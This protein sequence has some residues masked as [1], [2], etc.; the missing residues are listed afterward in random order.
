MQSRVALQLDWFNS[1]PSGAGTINVL[2]WD[3]VAQIGLTENL[4]LDADLPWSY[5][6]IDGVALSPSLFNVSKAVF[7]VPFVGA[8]LAARVSPTSGFFFGLGLGLPVQGTLSQGASVA[9]SIAASIRG[10]QDLHRFVPNQFP[11]RFRGGFELSAKP[12]YVQLD[13]APSFLISLDRSQGSIVTL[14]QGTNVGVRSSFGLLA[15]FR[16]QESF[17]LTTAA[18]HVQTALE[19]FVGYESPGKSG[20]TAR[21]GLLM[22]LDGIQGFA[23]DKG[24]LLTNRFSVG[25]KF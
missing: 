6:G 2:T 14:D 24:Q 19:P 20:L 17:F 4:F 7:G 12:F 8:H 11:L 15:G 23:F 1:S 5:T 13:L 22:P 21:Y 18:D 25:A 10:Y 9:A 16:F 3:L